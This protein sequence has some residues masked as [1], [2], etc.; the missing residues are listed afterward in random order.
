[1]EITLT[2]D[3]SK[4][5]IEGYTVCYDSAEVAVFALKENFDLM[6]GL[7]DYTIEQYGELVLQN[8]SFDSSVKLLSN[9]GLTYFDYEYANPETNDTYY[10]F[11]VLYKAP[12]AFWTVQ[13]TTLSEDIEDYIQSF[14]DWAKTVEFSE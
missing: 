3:F 13:F 11:T 10:Y 1:M 7:E 8:N 9:D 5:S 4:T 12:D 2:D 14:T 6:D